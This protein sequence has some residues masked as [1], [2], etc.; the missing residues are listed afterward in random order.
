MAALSPADRAAVFLAMP[1]PYLVLDPDLV[2]LDANPAYLRTVRRTLAE[3][4]G[5]E[6]V[7]VFPGSPVTAPD[8]GSP[9]RVSLERAR[10][11][12]RPDT[13]PVQEYAVPD[14]AGGTTPRFWSLTSIPV[15]DE[16]GRC[17]HL[18][19]RVEDITEY[20]TDMARG[21]DEAARGEAWRRRVV[22]A[23]SSLYARGVELQHARDAEA[24]AARRLAALAAVA[25]EVA[26]AESVAELSHVVMTRGLSA[27]G[28][29]GGAVA[30]RR[31]PVLEMVITDGLG[32]EAQ[33]LY[34]HLP[35]D[36][37]LPASV[38][39]RTGRP[40]LLRDAAE[41]LAYC[42]AMAEV[43]RTTGCQAWASLPLRVGDR[44]LGA[45]TLGWAA[46][47][48]FPAADRELMVAFAVQCAQ[49]LD[50]LRVRE[51]ERET[52]VVVRGLAEALQRTLLT[53]P[54]EPEHLQIAVRYLPAAREAQ[55]GGD[56]YD[57]FVLADGRTTLVIGDVSGHDQEAAAAMAQ[58]R[59]V[60][61]G[62]ASALPGTP[63]EVLSAL[64]RAMR[65]LAVG[66]Y[67]TGLLAT[68]EAEP[69]GP[70]TGGGPRRLRWSNAGHPPPLLVDPAGA[71][72][73]LDT[74]P[75]LLLGLDPDAARS[76]HE[77]LLSPGSTV[78]LYTDGLVERRGPDLDEGAA[79]LVDRVTELRDLPLERFCD[80][81]LSEL[82]GGTDDDVALLALRVHRDDPALAPAVSRGAAEPD[83]RRAGP[84]PGS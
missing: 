33:E 12:G 83:G 68:I 15:P 3:L 10:D 69:D 39:A 47:Q 62:I 71:V 6:L 43:A 49:T 16:L 81:L 66:T 51:A 54:P 35:L 84:G 44:V 59:N 76:D 27:L 11:T 42:A 60:L 20:V 56:W 5:H 80:E 21:V 24:A 46:P 50:R 63:A 19:Q 1:T 28:A 77:L 82:S 2:V 64:D 53:E 61:R 36:G 78:L 13:M 30:V 70:V 25:L 52:L 34:A 65:D 67:A 32:R 17:R 37:P 18:L 74:R 31:G 22:E 79:W 23:E 14:G 58:V 55:V 73:L 41:S 26:G 72:R 8:G 4:V 57:S 40:V 9:V 48:E 29:H 38:A 75:E 45:L 7:D